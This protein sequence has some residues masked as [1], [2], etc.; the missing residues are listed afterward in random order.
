M[1][2]LPQPF[3]QS[4]RV[5]LPG[6]LTGRDQATFRTQYEALVKTAHHLS[7]V[8]YVWNADK[9]VARFR[10]ENR[11]LYIGKTKFSL[12]ERYVTKVVDADVRNYWVRILHILSEYGGISIDVYQTAD[13]TQTEND[14]MFDY[15][16]SHLEMPPL[17]NQPFRMGLLSSAQKSLFYGE[18]T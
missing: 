11:V 4:K 6:V 16:L 5:T 1:R 7:G 10:G 15:F 2:N 8:V 12:A 14:F 18:Q 9:D 13:P 3:E 17:N